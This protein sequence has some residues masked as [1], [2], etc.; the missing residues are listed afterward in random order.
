MDHS[1]VGPG[2]D[3]DCMYPASEVLLRP[4]LRRLL[5]GASV[6]VRNVSSGGRS[7]QKTGVIEGHC[8]HPACAPCKNTQQVEGNGDV[9]NSAV[10]TSECRG[11]PRAVPPGIK[12]LV[13][14]SMSLPP[15]L[16]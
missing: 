13:T 12:S 9:L 16:I 6:E 7:E 14:D 2:L 3:P 15:L 5:A 10:L 8:S 11:W 1:Y 4:T